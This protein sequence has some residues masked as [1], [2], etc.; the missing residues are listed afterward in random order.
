MFKDSDIR[1]Y[2]RQ[3]VQK[4]R[5]GDRRRCSCITALMRERI[6]RFSLPTQRKTLRRTVIRGMKK[7]LTT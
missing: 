3:A 7:T 4:V 5:T 6:I 1:S 2:Y